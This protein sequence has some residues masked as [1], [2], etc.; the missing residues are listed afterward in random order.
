MATTDDPRT[1]LN[2]LPGGTES[3][4]SPALL[5][6]A[7]RRRT[8]RRLLAGTGTAAAVLAVVALTSLFSWKAGGERVAP[9]AS[10]AVSASPSAPA[11]THAERFAF[12]PEQETERDV[13]TTVITDLKLPEGEVDEARLDLIRIPGESKISPPSGDAGDRIREI[14]VAGTKVRV[15]EQTVD[16]GWDRQLEWIVGDTRYVLVADA[17][18][19]LAGTRYGPAEDDLRRLVERT[20]KR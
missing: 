9:V 6:D 14:T 20:L 8:R 17:Y 2:D 4:S 15:T 11:L 12:G 18:S 19:T 10:A 16:A 7:E 3:L 1:A 13:F 5:R